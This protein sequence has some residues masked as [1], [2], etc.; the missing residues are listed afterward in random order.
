MEHMD[1]SEDSRLLTQ[2]CRT[3]R[4]KLTETAAGLPGLQ[5]QGFYLANLASSLAICPQGLRSSP[6]CPG[7]TAG[8][9]PVILVKL[10]QLSNDIRSLA[11]RKQRAT[12][13]LAGLR[14][15]TFT[16]SHLQVLQ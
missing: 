10:H 7:Q 5:E 14:L 1:R 2:V 16:T 8:D 11:R 12:S 9:S 13:D 6:I 3:G 4:A 15:L